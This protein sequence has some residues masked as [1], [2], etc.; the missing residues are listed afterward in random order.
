MSDRPRDLAERRALLVARASLD[1]A[2]LTLAVHDLKLAISPPP[3]A[4]A[5]AR[6]RGIASKLVRFAVPLLGATR[7]GRWLRFAS[8]G[9]AV[10]R[11]ARG[12]RG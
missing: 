2:Q 5:A 10:L 12:W 7:A 11:I 6:G 3:S 9:L 8:I 4:E 1:R